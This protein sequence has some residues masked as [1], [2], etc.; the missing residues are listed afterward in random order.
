MTNN[1]KL[2]TNHAVYAFHEYREEEDGVEDDGDEVLDL[3][4]EGRSL[5]GG[6]VAS[7]DSDMVVENDK[8]Y[9]CKRLTDSS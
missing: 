5:V 8:C 1:T 2:A 6:G 7:V 9:F 3:V 4:V